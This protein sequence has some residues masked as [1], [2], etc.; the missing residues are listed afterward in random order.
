MNS[1]S[2]NAGSLYT[3]FITFLGKIKL[4]YSVFSLN[5]VMIR[6]NNKLRNENPASTGSLA[7]SKRVFF[8]HSICLARAGTNKPAANLLHQY[9]HVEID[10]AGSQPGFR[11]KKS[12]ACRK[13]VA[14]PHEL[15]ENLA[16]NLVENQVCSWLE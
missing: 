10:E 11:Q 15:V 1:V 13:H 12:K 5:Y 4:L 3:Q 2:H 6:T 14:N 16:A 9:R 8:L 7:G